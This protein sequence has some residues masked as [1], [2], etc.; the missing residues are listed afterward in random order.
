MDK[1][2]TILEICL[3]FAM[4]LAAFAIRLPFNSMP[5][6]RDEGTYAYIAQHVYSHELPYRDTFDHKPPFIY[7]IYKTAFDFFGI[8]AE[9]IRVFTTICVLISMVLVFILTR[10]FSN[11]W[12]ALLAALIYMV[13]QNNY[14][15]GGE[16]ANTEVFLQI[17]LLLAMLFLLDIEKKYEH[18][19]FFI[20]GIFI[21]VAFY[22]KTMVIFIF[23]VPLIYIFYYYRNIKNAVRYSVWYTCGFFLVTLLVFA[24]AIKNGIMNEFI[25]CNVLYNFFYIGGNQS[26][27]MPAL[28]DGLK[29]IIDTDTLLFL[30]FLWSVY[31]LFR[32][33]KERANFLI[34][35]FSATMYIGIVILK[36]PLLHYYLVLVPGFAILS[37]MMIWDFY[38]ILKEKMEKRA[39]IAVLIL[40]LVINLVVYIKVLKIVEYYKSGIYTMVMFHDSRAIAEIINRQKNEKTTL[41]VWPN[42]PEIYFLTGIKAPGRFIYATPMGYYKKD[43]QAL[44]EK[45]ADNPPDFFALTKDEKENMFNGLIKS[46]YDK[47]IET[48]N[49]ILYKRRK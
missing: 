28:A 27:G 17:P 45:I 24:W 22:V 38:L 20:A 8:S 23:L 44:F 5:L 12:V 19:S 14:M 32:E 4:V 25:D 29:F 6:D 15:M 26:T 11:R 3:L 33:P 36:G 43:F 48:S 42:E 1:R 7:Y 21:G 2:I 18:V 49:I 39:V 34:F 16:T 37:A 31:M 41:F 13:Y 35:F 30:S 46:F 9:S 40:A 47:Q 10:H